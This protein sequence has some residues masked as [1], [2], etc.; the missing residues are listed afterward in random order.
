MTAR[1][2]P[3]GQAV[4]LANFESHRPIPVRGL[5]IPAKRAPLDTELLFNSLH[6]AAD[7]LDRS[8]LHAQLDG[9]RAEEAAPQRLGQQ[10]PP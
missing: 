10:S 3:L 7:V 2:R 5:R 8:V 1:Y 4:A 9:G 6:R